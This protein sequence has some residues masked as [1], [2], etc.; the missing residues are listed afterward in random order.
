MLTALDIYKAQFKAM[1]CNK[2]KGVI[3]PH[4]VIML[5]AV[6][7]EIANGH[8]TNGF[9]PL[10]ETMVNA[11]K[12]VWN[13]YVQDTLIFK[14]NFETPFFHLSSEPFWSLVKSDDYTE[15]P[16]FSLGKLRK[17]FYGATIPDDLYALMQC[18]SDRRVLV[19]VLIEMLK[20]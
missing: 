2:Q 5:L 13:F 11:F 15:S 12:K 14:P 6:M 18:P 16:K 10:N 20:P 3:A 17:S 9:I 4:K 1:R 7:E 8:I 19:R